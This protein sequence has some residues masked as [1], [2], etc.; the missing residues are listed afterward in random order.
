[1]VAADSA[2]RFG[3]TRRGFTLIE[4]LVVIGIIGILF[5]ILLPTL[6]RVRELGSRTQC[7]SNL[8]QFVIATRVMA[9]SNKQRFR[10]SHRELKE[11]DANAR[12]YKALAYLASQPDHIT[13]LSKHLFE[14]Y[15]TEGGIDLERVTCPVRVGRAGDGNN[16]FTKDDGHRIRTGFYLMAGRW[17]SQFTLVDGRRLVSPIRLSDK[18]TLVLASDAVEEGTVNGT[19][20]DAQ[21]SIPHGRAG[22]AMSSGKSTPQALGSQGSNVAYMDG[23]IIFERQSDLQ[24]H[25]ASSSAGVIGYWPEPRR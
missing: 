8:R 4:L 11:V 19:L 9:E 18:A 3:R 15:R 7:A 24:R 21:S 1:M 12:D 13:W 10:L 17:D 23:S 2:S 20:L 22:L 16:G 25:A 14:R 5:S 6:G